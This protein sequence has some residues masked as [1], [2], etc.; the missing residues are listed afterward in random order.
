MKGMM[1][2]NKEGGGRRHCRKYFWLNFKNG[3]KNKPRKKPA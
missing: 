1:E 3:P 2:R